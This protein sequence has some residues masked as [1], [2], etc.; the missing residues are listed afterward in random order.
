VE[1]LTGRHGQ[2][3]LSIR[4]SADGTGQMPPELRTRVPYADLENG[5]VSSQ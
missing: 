2:R 1:S 3:T 4:D 5:P